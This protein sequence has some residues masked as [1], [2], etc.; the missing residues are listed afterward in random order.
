[1]AYILA[2]HCFL[3][4][5]ASITPKRGRSASTVSRFCQPTKSGPRHPRVSSACCGVR[6]SSAPWVAASTCSLVTSNSSYSSRRIV[7][8]S[9]WPHPLHPCCFT[10]GPGSS[11]HI[12]DTTY[13]VTV[14]VW[15]LDGTCQVCISPNV[16]RCPRGVWSGCPHPKAPSPATLRLPIALLSGVQLGVL[17]IDTVRLNDSDR[18]V[19]LFAPVGQKQDD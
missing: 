8:S 13:H 1:M 16:Y 2:L 4:C 9:Y 10:R 11:L 18:N 15:Q 14:D 19:I 5:L 6:V 17:V 3:D 7:C 12:L